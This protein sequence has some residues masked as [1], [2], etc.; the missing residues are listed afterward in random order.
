M[1]EPL[2]ISPIAPSSLENDGESFSE[3]SAKFR[4]VQA[5]HGLDLFTAAM[6]EH[7]TGSW[8]VTI[9]LILVGL[10]AANWYFDLE[11]EYL[12][13]AYTKEWAQIVYDFVM[14]IPQMLNKMLHTVKTA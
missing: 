1:L 8:S 10:F 11:R 6:N 9:F 2:P 4:F 5:D 3:H 7:N 12:G 14:S 13:H